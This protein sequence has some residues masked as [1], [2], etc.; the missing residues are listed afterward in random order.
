M[1]ALITEF[2][3]FIHF[4]LYFLF[5]NTEKR[6]EYEKQLKNF[7]LNK[8]LVEKRHKQDLNTLDHDIGILFDQ[9]HKKDMTRSEVLNE[10]DT[11]R[12]DICENQM[13]EI[14][15]IENDIVYCEKM[16]SKHKG[17]LRKIK[18]RLF[19]LF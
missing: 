15:H 6:V 9:R 13:N 17:L 5:G 18:E 16:I 3:K 1:D 10:W 4:I 8:E 2:F 14:S 11:R 19:L 12:G 7:Q